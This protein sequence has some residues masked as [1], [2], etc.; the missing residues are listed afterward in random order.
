MPLLYV[1][2]SFLWGVD[3]PGAGG[4]AVVGDIINVPQSVADFQI[5]NG[6]A[7]LVE[8]QDLNATQ[9]DFTWV[10]D[11]VN[12]LKLRFFGVPSRYD[13]FNFF[14]NFGF[15]ND[16]GIK[17]EGR[18]RDTIV[19]FPAAGYYN[20]ELLVRQSGFPA[21]LIQVPVGGVPARPPGAPLITT[22]NGVLPPAVVGQAYGVE[23]AY[24][25]NEP[26]TFSVVGGTLPAGLQLIGNVIVGTPTSVTSQIFTIKA[27]NSLGFDDALFEIEVAASAVPPNALLTQQNVIITA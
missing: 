8:N 10:V 18:G 19:T 21:R 4:I 12:P 6:N 20:V 11:P 24:T 27:Q 7:T 2:N 16:Q 3:I 15:E 22:S 26:V 14:W 23:L 13:T 25:G 5:A 17:V 1:E 9:A